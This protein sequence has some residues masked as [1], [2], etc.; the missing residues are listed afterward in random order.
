[1]TG[2]PQPR[3]SPPPVTRAEWDDV[4]SRL[5]RIESKITRLLN[6]HGLDHNGDPLPRTDK[7]SERGTP[8][9]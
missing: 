3:H 5:V 2:T 6:A 4:R 9:P 1:M 7:V 8:P